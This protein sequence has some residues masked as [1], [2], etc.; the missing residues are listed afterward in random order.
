VIHPGA[1]VP[2]RRWPPERFAAVGDELAGHGLAVM[3]T[4]GPEESPITVA[5]QQA[6]RAT[7]IDL[8]GRTTLGTLGA[9]LADAALLVSNDTGVM[10]VAEAVGTP[11]VAV[12]F[13]P[14]S[15]R[16]EPSDAERYRV[17]RGGHAVTV[18]DVLTAMTTL[19]GSRTAT[20]EAD[21]SRLGQTPDG[22]ASRPARR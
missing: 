9:L 5:V 12:S 6:M 21:R 13:D 7:A 11:L 2:E 19:L 15:W 3:L 20:S 14:E 1:S 8:T 4:G 22:R 10:H 17:L 16:W 18:R